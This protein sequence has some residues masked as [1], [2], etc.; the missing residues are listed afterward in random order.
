MPLITG[1]ISNP[2]PPNKP[3]VNGAGSTRLMSL[4]DTSRRWIDEIALSL[5]RPTRP[6]PASASDHEKP[7][8]GV[9]PELF[10][11]AVFP[12]EIGLHRA[13]RDIGALVGTPVTV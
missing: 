2:K 5:S 11:Q 12:I 1:T 8:T 4:A 9:A 13:R 7:V 3:C 10:D 6:S